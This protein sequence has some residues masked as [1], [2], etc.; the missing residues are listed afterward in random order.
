MNTTLSQVSDDDADHCVEP[1]DD[2]IVALVRMG[3][4]AMFEDIVHRHGRLLHRVACRIVRDSAEAEDVVQETFTRALAM[5]PQYSGSGRFV[6]WLTRIAV[7]EALGRKRQQKRID[8]GHR[9]GDD[10][11][12]LAVTLAATPRGTDP[13][14]CASNSQLGA[15]LGHAIERL[16]SHFRAV[17]ELRAVEELSTL[18]TAARLGIPPQ[19]VKTRFHRAKRLLRSQ[20]SHHYHGRRRATTHPGRRRAD[21][22]M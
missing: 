16:P 15:L 14:S 8:A 3:R 19:T 17:F 5:L 4:H 18:E 2:E 10:G 1:T 21:T 9:V 22:L 12:V 13:E 20:L 7:H 11:Q 6:G